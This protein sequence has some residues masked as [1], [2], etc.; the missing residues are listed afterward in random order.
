MMRFNS[1]SLASGTV[2]T[3]FTP[4]LN[5]STANSQ[6]TISFWMYRDNGYTGYADKVDVYVNTTAA[7]GG[8]LL[9]TVNRSYLLS[10]AVGT[11]NAWYQYT[12]TIPA[13]YNTSTN[14]LIFKFTSAY[15]NNCFV[16]D[17]VLTQS[18]LTPCSGTP[19]TTASG[20]ATVCPNTAFT[21]S[22]TPVAGTGVTYQWK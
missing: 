6:Y 12:Y 22:C 5:F 11:P 13:S 8:T 18:I 9:G 15:G 16:D 17:I 20:P 2:G 4:V 1:Y 3:L 21:L 10:P 7:A 19:T 14:Y